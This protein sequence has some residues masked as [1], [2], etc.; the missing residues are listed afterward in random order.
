V[1][2]YYETTM[3]VL[4]DLEADRHPMLVVLNK[5]DKLDAS[6][7]V[8]GELQRRYP[9]SIPVSTRDHRGLDELVRHIEA[10]ADDNGGSGGPW[11]S[12]RG[13]CGGGPPR[14]GGAGS[15]SGGGP[16]GDDPPPELT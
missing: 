9:G 3:A 13:R 1:D 4:R 10:L 6:D 15:P 5:I 7:S 14:G 8:L 2:K 11:A 12:R 16:G